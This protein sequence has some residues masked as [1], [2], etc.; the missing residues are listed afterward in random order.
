MYSAPIYFLAIG[1]SLKK[2]ITKN[3]KIVLQ[4]STHH[5]VTEV[6]CIGNTVEILND[7][8]WNKGLLSKLYQDNKSK[9][10]C[11]IKVAIVHEELAMCGYTTKR[12]ERE[13][14]A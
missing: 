4:T 6:V 3:K 14:Q 5:A 10:G 7:E 11:V 9:N 12:F 13:Y 8:Y 2:Y 1:Y